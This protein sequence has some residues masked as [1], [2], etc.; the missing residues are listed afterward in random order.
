MVEVKNCPHSPAKGGL[1]KEKEGDKRDK[2]GGEVG[3]IMSN[4][5]VPSTNSQQPW[6]V[7][8]GVA[9]SRIGIDRH[10]G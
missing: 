10:S 6:S 3:G 1:I 8:H 4:V 9:A 2:A 5:G 7:V